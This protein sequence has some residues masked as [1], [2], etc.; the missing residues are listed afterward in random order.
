MPHLV[1]MQAR[2][3]AIAACCLGAAQPPAWLALLPCLPPVLQA[4]SVEECRRRCPGLVV[5][6][7]RTD[8]YRE[9]SFVEC[10]RKQRHCALLGT[11]ACSVPWSWLHHA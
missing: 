6:P 8:R 10:D 11:C 3:L 2:A 5:R 4:A 9:V 1:R 7:M